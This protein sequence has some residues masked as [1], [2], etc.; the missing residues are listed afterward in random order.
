MKR[1][2]LFSQPSEKAVEKLLPQLFPS[3]WDQKALAYMPSNGHETKQIYTDF[4]KDLAQKNMTDF[5]LVDNMLPKGSGEEEKIKNADILLISGGNTFELLNNLRNS[6]LD[7]A[8]L[9]FVKKDNYVLAGFSAGA[10]VLSPT[11]AIA[12]QPSGDDPT[13]LIDENR[14]GI[15]DLTGLNIINFEI[16]P[17]YIEETDRKTL[18]R[19][20]LQTKNEVKT[21]TND[22]LIIINI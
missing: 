12:G 10:I 19:Y 5:A 7:Q 6:G 13:D 16:L 14:V 22:D 11:I 4:W 17:H 21:V 9:D 2:I 15:T 3:D 20:Q 8:I 18:E 1:I